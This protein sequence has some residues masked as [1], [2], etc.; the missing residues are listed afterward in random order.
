MSYWAY[1]HGTLSL[2]Q[3]FWP[4]KDGYPLAE[5]IGLTAGEPWSY[6]KDGGPN[7]DD[8]PAGEEGSVY[9]NITV[10]DIGAN[11][12]IAH[13]QIHGNLREFYSPTPIFEWLK[14]VA[15]PFNIDDCMVQITTYNGRDL[16]FVYTEVDERT[17]E[18]VLL[19][20]DLIKSINS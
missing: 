9:Y 18:P 15:K 6:Y 17:K 16:Y 2:S 11:L 14:K 8:I 1:V 5:L 7:G 10:E 12:H 13:M 19:M 4:P 20:T 3:R